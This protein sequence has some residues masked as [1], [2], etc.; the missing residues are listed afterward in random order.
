MTW[1]Q[2]QGLFKRNVYKPESEPPQ[3]PATDDYSELL[4]YLKEYSKKHGEVSLEEF[5]GVSQ[6]EFID[7]PSSDV[8]Y[9]GNFQEIGI[10]VVRAD[11][12][13]CERCRNYSTQV[14]C[15][16]QHPTLCPRCAEFIA[17][18]RGE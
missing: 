13:K 14:G 3:E 9:K 2:T 16:S 11:G 4:N 8:K 6:V 5:F 10:G 1:L 12:H 18:S 7:S 15:S 17:A